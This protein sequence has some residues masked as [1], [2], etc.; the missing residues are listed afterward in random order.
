MRNSWLDPPAPPAAPEETEYTIYLA[1]NYSAGLALGDAVF[2][3]KLNDVCTKGKM[4]QCKG[5]RLRSRLRKRR[6]QVSR[7]VA[8]EGRLSVHEVIKTSEMMVLDIVFPDAV[9]RMEVFWDEEARSIVGGGPAAV[10]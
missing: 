9:I 2:S 5:F 10:A 3:G 1:G 7:E 8:D 6:T 4:M